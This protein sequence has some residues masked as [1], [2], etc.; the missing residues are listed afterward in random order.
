MLPQVCNALKYTAGFLFVIAALLLVGLLLENNGVM[1]DE[2]L[3]QKLSLAFSGQCCNHVPASYTW[4]KPPTPNPQPSSSR[5]RSS[6]LPRF[7]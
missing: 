4:N 1:S 3:I 2:A 5:P 7:A 6:T